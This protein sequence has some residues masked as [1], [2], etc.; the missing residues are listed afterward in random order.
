MSITVYGTPVSTY[1]RTVRLLLAETNVNYELKDINIFNGENKTDEYLAK[2]PFGKVPT[3]EI[4][5]IKIYETSAITYYINQKLAAGQYQPSELLAQTRMYQIIG[6]I[7]SHLY[8][9]A[10]GTIVIQNLIVPSQGGKTN[11]EA[12]QKAIAP[13]QK[14]L[15]AIEELLIGGSFLVGSKITIADFYLIPIFVYL[16][17]TPQFNEIMANVPQLKTWWDQVKILNNVKK[18]CA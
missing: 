5:G 17:K 6:I 12:V 2:N 14:A 9:H 18:I 7:D 10:I 8:S 15:K 4:E 13:T 3:I 11:Q 1:V 16:E